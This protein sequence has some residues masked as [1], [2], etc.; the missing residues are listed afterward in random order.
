LGLAFYDK[1]SFPEKYHNGEFVAQHGSWNRSI[2][3]GYK[4]VFVPFTNG[5]PGK[6]GD[7]LAG[8]VSDLSSSEVYGR[9]VCVVLTKDVS[10]LISDDVSNAIWKVSVN[11]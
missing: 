3:P 8:F 11:K 6:P 1:K 5:K 2:I 4:V 7:F 10:L 9:P